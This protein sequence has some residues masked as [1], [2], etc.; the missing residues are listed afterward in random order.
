M[1]LVLVVMSLLR[2][3]QNPDV[4]LNFLTITI[5]LEVLLLQPKVWLNFKRR[6]FL[7][8]K[9]FL[10]VVVECKKEASPDLT[11]HND[12][13]IAELFH[14][15]GQIGHEYA[16]AGNKIIKKITVF[17]LLIDYK[18]DQTK[19]TYVLNMPLSQR[20][21]K[22]VCEVCITYPIN[23]TITDGVH[24]LREQLNRYI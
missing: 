17:G 20:S 24:L 6:K 23:V 16:R 15:A 22:E 1:Y 9:Q 3:S 18:A 2:C 19:S 14:V 4:I 21:S 12:Q 8:V 5:V 7:N 13:V 10:V 11:A